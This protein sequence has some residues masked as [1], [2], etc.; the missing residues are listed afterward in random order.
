[1]E[2]RV[3][4]RFSLYEVSDC[5]DLRRSKDGVTYKKGY[6]LK[7]FIDGDGY[8]KYSLV[9][10]A[11]NKVSVHS[12]VLVAE[13]FIGPK[14]D[15]PYEVA[16]DN[17]SRIMNHFSNLRWATR[18]ENSDDRVIH[19]TVAAGESNGRA[20]I[21]NADVISIRREYELA[22]ALDVRGREKTEF[23]KALSQL[24]GLSVC[25]LKKIA[26]RQA[27]SHIK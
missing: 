7:G 13:A 22:M 1:M 8:L 25:Q 27:W 4:P 3:C 2:W 19:G 21:T 9:D 5:G 6:G 16:H 10:D 12:H 26:K 23:W 14:P 15:G 24:Y 20:M 17:G 11:G 18:K